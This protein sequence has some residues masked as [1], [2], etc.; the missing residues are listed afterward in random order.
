MHLFQL[1]QHS[2]VLFYLH[3]LYRT[4]RLIIYLGPYVLSMLLCLQCLLLAKVVVR[5]VG[6]VMVVV[7]VVGVVSLLT[8]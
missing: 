6:V 2:Q 1:G 8:L 7:V 5:V 4:V 3:H